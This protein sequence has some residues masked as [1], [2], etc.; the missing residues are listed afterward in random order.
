MDRSDRL[1]LTC[2][3]FFKEESSC[4]DG[5]AAISLNKAPSRRRASRRRDASRRYDLS[6]NL[7]RIWVEKA[8]A[9]AL[10]EDGAA[11]ELFT[12]CEARIAALERLAGRQALKIETSGA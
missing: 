3:G 12:A 8:E 9:G 11:A 2:A 4:R 6:R 7:I 5:N 10:D 1:E